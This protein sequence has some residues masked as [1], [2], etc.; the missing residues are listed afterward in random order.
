MNLAGEIH[1]LV[2][3]SHHFLLASFVGWSQWVQY[4]VCT[5][6]CWV[7]LLNFTCYLKNEAPK[8]IAGYGHCMPLLGSTLTCLLLESSRLLHPKGLL[9]PCFSLNSTCSL[10]KSYVS[11]MKSTFFRDK[12][13]CFWSN[14]MFHS[15]FSL[16]RSFPRVSTRPFPMAHLAWQPPEIQR[17]ASHVPAP[18]CGPA[19]LLL[20]FFCNL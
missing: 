3:Q 16:V 20:C 9:R 4:P 19:V 11:E 2:E 1:I 17:S 15:K 14:P 13:L 10:I 12:N 5:N 8:M 18:R 6:S 7:H